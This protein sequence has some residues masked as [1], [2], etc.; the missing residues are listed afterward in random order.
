MKKSSLSRLE[1]RAWEIMRERAAQGRDVD[2]SI[3][4]A[5]A[6]TEH[7]NKRMRARERK[8]LRELRG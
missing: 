3:A 4:Y 7:N 5:A 1:E 6:V 2:F 8:R